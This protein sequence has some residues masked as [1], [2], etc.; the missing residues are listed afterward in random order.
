[1]KHTKI[2]F[3]T[4]LLVFVLLLVGCGST[5]EEKSADAEEAAPVE[6]VTITVWDFGGA[7]F[8]WMDGLAIPAFE[9]KFPHIT[10][11]HVG[12]TEDELGLKLETSIA[13]GKAPDLVLFPPPRVITTGLA[14]P[15]DDFMARDGI[16]RE[17]YCPI[18]NSDNLFAGGA[19]YED[20]VY[21]LPID[22]NVWAMAYNKDMFVE[23]GLP[24]LKST[25]YIDFDTWLKYARAIN[26]PTEN[27]EDR[28]WGSVIFQPMFNAMNNYMSDPYVLGDDGRTCIGNIDTPEWVHTF[29]VLK[30]AWE[31]DLTTET[32]GAMLA[33]IEET[34]MFFQGKLGMTYAALGDALAA[35]EMGINVGFT[36]QPVVTEGWPVN[37][38]GWNSTYYM[39]RSTEHPD[40]AWEFLK[41]LSTEAPL[42]IPFASDIVGSSD[43]VSGLTGLPCYLPLLEEE[44]FKTMI[45]ND[46]LVADTVEL[47]THYKSPPFSPDI[48]TTIDPFW[49]GWTRMTEGGEDVATVI[50]EVAVE[51]Q[52]ILDELWHSIP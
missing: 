25:D 49:D 46:S 44:K 3:L 16:K 43:T 39:M 51:C 22:T 8:Q 6:K 35:R 24:E 30:S 26:K 52:D 10:I 4:L 14:L 21:G 42:I 40:E 48:W 12:L 37:A 9:E 31:E 33:D 2:L 41:W 23:A 11:K 15:L 38:G 19:L 17:D 29:E 34:E 13:A 47:T 45:E 7:E 27:M 5:A 20:K 28:V 32:A 18:F 50:S 1:M 36:G